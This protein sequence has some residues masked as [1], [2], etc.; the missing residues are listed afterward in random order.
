MSLRSGIGPC[1]LFFVSVLGCALLPSAV[2]HAQLRAQPYVSGLS[3]PVAFIAD[4]TTPGRHFVVE[5]MGHI[6][7]VVDG[8]LQERDFLDVSSL[9][10]PRTPVEAERGLL[11]MALAPDYATSGRFFIAF[12]REGTSPEERGDVVVS[13]FKR[14]LS[15]PQ[16][17]DPSS[18]FDLRWGSP[19]G[20]AFI[21][22]S[23]RPAHNGGSMVFGADG[24]LYIGLGDGGGNGDP[25]GNA[26]NPM[27]LKGKIL[28]IDVNVP[29]ND[30]QGYRVPLDNPFR[31]GVPIAARPE[32]WAFGVRN[33]WR[34]VFDEAALGG[35]GA[36]VIAD[37]GQDRWEEINYE[38][39]GQGGRNYGWPILEGTNDYF[40]P[41]NPGYVAPLPAFL[42]LTN[43]AFEYFHSAGVS[44]VEGNSVTGGYIYRGTGLGEA[45]RGRYFFSDFAVAHMWSAEVKPQGTWATFQNIVDHTADVATGRLSSFAADPNGELYLV[46]Y[47]ATGQGVVS[48][49]CGFTVNPNV[50]SFSS[51]GGTG[52]IQVTAPPGCT[53]SVS[54]IGSG[55]ALIS[56]AQISGS[57]TVQFRVPAYQADADRETTLAVAGQ[58]VRLSLRAAAPTDGDINGDG[59]ADLLWQHADGRMSAW[60]MNG[61]TLKAGVQFG[62]APLVDTRWRIAASGD[63][64]GDGGRD[65][66][67][68]HDTSGS[69]AA[70]L[71]SGTTLLAG[72]DIAQVPETAW[73][74]RGS[75]DMDRDGWPDLVWQHEGD[76]RLSVWLMQG[77]TLREGRLIEM[78]LVP[79]HDW[80]IVAIA[81]MNG[82]A[83]PDLVWQNGANGLLA[84]WLMNGL[85]Y[86]DGV[87]LSPSSVDDTNWR[88]V[89]TG[90][91]NAD[92]KADL[93]WRHQTTGIMAAWLMNGNQ[94]SES[95]FLAPD[96]VADTGWKIVGTK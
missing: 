11:G 22:H 37:V 10:T 46:R 73:K 83:A 51:A 2:A 6:R 80:R 3:F 18:R 82:D 55:V 71:M 48:R 60:F 31:D 45:M 40:N 81:D 61:T 9:V 13:R 50:T 88:I 54:D 14:G 1:R 7:V 65:V 24:Y 94:V 39:I 19:T 23:A 64:D 5:Q 36:L 15:E 93:I 29:D 91:F 52:T 41:E 21:D 84:T 75:A 49:L 28:R 16:L 95:V 32:I 67:F 56:N 44:L 70:W 25:D 72:V 62:P 63:F 90:D 68:Q 8:V 57:G 79:D 59:A 85:N 77:T 86:V 43:P 78:P 35:T 66:I 58:T 4:P 74:I 76:G 92:G 26:Q 30:A 47:G 33:P 69:I 87:L 27:E 38:P 53:W 12:T 17:A 20:P 34:L 96:T 42:P 89:A